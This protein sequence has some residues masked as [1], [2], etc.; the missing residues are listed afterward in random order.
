MKKSYVISF[1]TVESNRQKVILA[2]KSYHTWAKLNDTSWMIVSVLSAKEIRDNLK[3][4]FLP[5]DKFIV[6][7]AANSAAW[8]NFKTSTSDWFKKHIN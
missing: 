8:T 1:E 7:A 4:F 6:I 3:P 5:T 2:I